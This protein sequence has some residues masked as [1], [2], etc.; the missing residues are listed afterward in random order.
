MLPQ[1]EAKGGVDAPADVAQPVE[2]RL[3]LAMRGG[4]SLAIWMG[5][6]CSE[7]VRLHAASQLPDQAPPETRKAL[8]DLAGCSTV[9]VD[10]LAGTSAGGLNGSLLAGHL[11]YG[12]DF[13][14]VRDL[15]LRLGDLE[16]LARHPRDHTPP[17]LLHGDGDGGGVVGGGFYTQLRK[18]M[19]ELL[20]GAQ[21]TVDPAL[22]LILTTTRLDAPDQFLFPWSGA[23]LRAPRARAY[24][25]FRRWPGGG[26][27]SAAPDGVVDQ[28]AYAARCT[29]SFPMAFEPGR[30][31]VRGAVVPE[32]TPRPDMRGACSET[33]LPDLSAAPAPGPHDAQVADGGLLDNVP[34]AWAIR[35][36]AA[37]RATAPVDRWL[38]Y[39]QPVPSSVPAAAPGK[40]RSPLLRPLALLRSA[41]GAKT[42][43]PLSEDI[44]EL[45]RARDAADRRLAGLAQLLPSG[46]DELLARGTASLAKYQ[47]Q[48]GTAQGR[49]LQRLLTDPAALTGPDP[50]PFDGRAR[51]LTS[52]LAVD[53]GAGAT[54]YLRD[55][56]LLADELM[57]PTGV[58]LD[59][60]ASQARSP[61]ALARTVELCL[62]WAWAAEAADPQAQA[63]LAS[64]RGTLY[65]LRLAVETLL[66]IRDR[67]VLAAVT[68]ANLQK[69]D[70]VD[71]VRRAAAAAELWLTDKSLSVADA[72]DAPAQGWAQWAQDAAAAWDA[73]ADAGA[74]GSEDAVASML[75]NV[76]DGWPV[77]AQARLW[78]A[79]FSVA[80]DVAPLQAGTA[81]MP[82]LAAAAAPGR[83]NQLQRALAAAEVLL[84][85]LRP[86]PLAEATAFRFVVT[87]AAGGSPVRN[88]GSPLLL[89]GPE[90]LAGNQVANF[91]SFLSVRWRLN[92][93]IWGRLDGATTLAQVLAE[94]I[95][96][97][98][99]QPA[100]GAPVEDAVGPALHSFFTSPMAEPTADWPDYLASR[101]EAYSG[102]A[103]WSAAEVAHVISERLH[104]EILREELPLLAKLDPEK[105]APSSLPADL[106]QGLPLPSPAELTAQAHALNSVGEESV[107]HLLGRWGLR[108]TAV[109]L[110]LVGWRA[111]QPAGGP[112]VLASTLLM[113]PFKPL[114]V[115]GLLAW[116]APVNSAVASGI[117]CAAVVHATGELWSWAQLLPLTTLAVAVGVALRRRTRPT[118]FWRSSGLG[119]L[120]A[121]TVALA[122]RAALAPLQGVVDRTPIGQAGLTALLSG[123][124]ACLTLWWLPGRE[125]AQGKLLRVGLWLGTGV[126]AAAA[127]RLWLE[128]MD[129]VWGAEAGRLAAWEAASCLYFATAV[130][131]AVLTYLYPAP[132]QHPPT[133]VPA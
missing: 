17:S 38:L 126:A 51:P 132:P 6:V 24:F 67:F 112:G 39:L 36:I 11:A 72:A 79:L 44:A 119:V 63:A 50:L 33:G 26:A 29:S 103:V 106:G 123:V 88:N 110:G 13:T 58:T 92:D 34:V 43:E 18:G 108:R 91:A 65:D 85:A 53:G 113:S 10:V 5:G 130:V 75:A 27:G 54:A 117:A 74:A 102:T 59:S 21:P 73:D 32:E 90:K 104:L 105:D 41:L 47:K 48:V 83:P 77:N 124:V 66:A 109:R 133:T 131:T 99:G 129:Q 19:K 28:L 23:P 94:R 45:E 76:G 81:R 15:W 46:L 16:G 62:D 82:A 22:T 42:Q 78:E 8:L 128:L 56:E 125:R 61:L 7:V 95:A 60:L 68:S 2:L 30:V 69:P 55:L 98:P 100:D 115:A 80:G 25:L 4:V 127:V 40:A 122:S 87:S 57:A 86:D 96:K 3:A 101:W 31:H 118:G 93:W 1:V 89:S 52:L 14:G 84:G 37:A 64:A 71:D 111:L 107:R 35:A 20:E 114:A 12:M 49:R 70:A 116:L 120:A 121:T 9:T 97:P